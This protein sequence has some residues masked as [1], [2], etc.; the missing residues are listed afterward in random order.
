M[1]DPAF[2]KALRD[3]KF[4]ERLFPQERLRQFAALRR[5]ADNQGVV[6]PEAIAPYR[7]PQVIAMSASGAIRQRVVR[8]GKITLISAH[9]G[10]A[11]TTGD[12][13]LSIT[14]L[15]EDSPTAVVIAT[16]TIPNG[17]SFGQSAPMI[18]VDTGQW[19][20]ASTT[21]SGSGSSFSVSINIT[22]D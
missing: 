4:A 14:S 5:T 21:S 15:S 9:A 17:Q 19:L 12:A 1:S 11:P 10:T 18:S 6:F 8:A 20:L 16:V 3:I 13:V 7:M 22:Q 2:G